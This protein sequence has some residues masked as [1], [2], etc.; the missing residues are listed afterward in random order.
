MYSNAELLGLCNNNCMTKNAAQPDSQKTTQGLEKLSAEAFA[1]SFRNSAPYINRHRDS[2]FVLAFGG[3]VI[4]DGR[5][6]HLA[7]DIALLQALGIKL[8]LVHGARPQIEERLNARGLDY[9]YANGLRITDPDALQAEIDACGAIRVNIEARLSYSLRNTPMAGIRLRVVS[10]NFVT[11]KPLGVLNGID[12]QHTGSVR[13]VDVK[14]IQAALA[15]QAIVLLSPLGY[16]P[17]GE[18]FNCSAEQVATA[19]SEALGADKLI[20]L[21][22]LPE[23]FTSDMTSQAALKMSLD[24]AQP[25]N[26]RTHLRNSAHAVERGVQR[27]HI[28]SATDDGALLNELFTRD[29]SGC[30]ITAAPYDQLRQAN[31]DDIPNILAVIEP[32][33]SDGVLVERSREQLELDIAHYRVLERDGAVLGCAAL[34]IY[35]DHYAELACVAVA[36]AYRS[37]R[38][39]NEL[40]QAMQDEAHEAGV[41]QLFV[42]T[43][44]SPHWFIEHGFIEAELADLPIERQNLYNFQRNSKVLIKAL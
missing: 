44:Q 4:A 16:S 39:G 8:V 43:T 11:A 31:A 28:V 23:N 12:F 26:L 24:E 35:G 17:T 14:A 41:Q 19:V 27:A 5:F 18:V 6:T 7:Q 37:T 15:Q 40:L 1:H 32:L 20:F 25:D 34:Y 29:G 30:L 9:H 21:D 42:L 2:T 38:R 33:E 10:G 13:K 3:D 22:S 36:E